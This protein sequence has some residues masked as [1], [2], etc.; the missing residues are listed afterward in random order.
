MSAGFGAKF[1][2]ALA[3]DFGPAAR[4]PAKTSILSQ[5]VVELLSSKTMFASKPSPTTHQF[6]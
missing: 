2:M 6:E 5:L 3:P 1:R 4:V